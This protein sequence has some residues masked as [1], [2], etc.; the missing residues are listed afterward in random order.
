M[1]FP[2]KSISS[3]FYLVLINSFF[4]VQVKSAYYKLIIEII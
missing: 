2:I 3:L 1:H 4:D